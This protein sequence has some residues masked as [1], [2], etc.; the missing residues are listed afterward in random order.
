MAF[1]TYVKITKKKEFINRESWVCP[2]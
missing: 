2:N 1:V